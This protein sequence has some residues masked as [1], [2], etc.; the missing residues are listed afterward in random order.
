[1]ETPLGTQGQQKILHNTSQFRIYEIQLILNDHAHHNFVFP[2]DAMLFVC[3]GQL[4]IQSNLEETSLKA[5]QAIWLQHKL[6]FRCVTI[7][8]S[9]RFLII[10]F[11]NQTQ[12]NSPR[13]ERFASGTED[14]KQHRTGVTQWTVSNK[15]LAK[16]EWFMFPAK[17]QEPFYY[18]KSS[19]QFIV[20]INTESGLQ[21][22]FNGTPVATVPAQGILIPNG[23]TRSLI[24]CSSKP[25]TFLSIAAPFPKQSRI[26]KL[27]RST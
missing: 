27:S 10:V 7:S 12:R 8:P 25:I 14:K 17:H 20:P 3:D 24:N 26:M 15:T 6:P 23:K 21:I 5:N 18:L 1:M 4:F 19:E 13:F 2:F 16:I 9:T 22:K 11:S